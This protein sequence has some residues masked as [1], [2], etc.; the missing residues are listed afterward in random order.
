MIPITK[1]IEHNSNRYI[2][3]SALL[4]VVGSQLLTAAER[5]PLAKV[6]EE[7]D[8]LWAKVEAS[9]PVKWGARVE[10]LSQRVQTDPS[11][12]DEF[13]AAVTKPRETVAL[14]H[15]H[16][17]AKFNA[18]SYSLAPLAIRATKHL[19]HIVETRLVKARE[20]FEAMKQELPGADG[21]VCAIPEIELRV[22]NTLRSWEELLVDLRKPSRSKA[23][24]ALYDYGLLPIQSASRQQGESNVHDPAHLTAALAA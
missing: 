16:F 17:H 11:L 2:D 3:T 20:F 4:A 19:I 10:Q 9:D 1:F 24:V 12:L 23:I 21:G 7:I 5:K 14:E 22:K 8:D 13:S 15:Q 18:L 6:A